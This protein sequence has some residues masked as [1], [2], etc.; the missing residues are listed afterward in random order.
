[1]C[2]SFPMP[3]FTI[4]LCNLAIG[5]S[6]IAQRICGDALLKESDSANN[7][8]VADLFIS[9]CCPPL[10]RLAAVRATNSSCE[11]HKVY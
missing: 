8:S 6:R 4:Q 3:S 10:S 5:H 9:H 2:A 11:T 7:D 1:M